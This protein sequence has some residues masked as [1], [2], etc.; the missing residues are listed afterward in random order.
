MFDLEEDADDLEYWERDDIEDDEPIFG[1]LVALAE[2]AKEGRA[3]LP[4]GWQVEYL[5]PQ[6]LVWTAPSGRR[7]AST[8]EGHM[9]P[10]P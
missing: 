10:M 2:K 6:T 7:R 4:P 5:D 8:I 1:R 3:Q 9:I